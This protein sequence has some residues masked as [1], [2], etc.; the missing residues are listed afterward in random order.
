[1]KKLKA[2]F[3]ILGISVSLLSSCS[4]SDSNKDQSS[5]P[6]PENAVDYTLSVKSEGG[7]SIGDVTVHIFDKETKTDL[8]WAGMTDEDGNFSFKADGA[9]EYVAVVTG[10]AEGYKVEP[11]YSLSK[12]TEIKL[13]TVLL[14]PN[15]ESD[16]YKLGDIV[17]DF[18]ITDVNGN[19]YKMSELLKEKKAV[20]LNFWFIG[21]GP[22]KMEFP[23]MQEAYG[24]FKDEIEILAINAYDGTDKTVKEYAAEM[25]LT[26]PML[27]CESEWITMFRI[28]AFPTTVVIDRYGMVAFSHTGSITDKA[29]FTKI[30][31]HFVSDGYVQNTYRNISDIK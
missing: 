1:M 30:F 11:E 12:N 14:E 22:C 27:S 26:M 6:V 28:S 8:V 5:F 3:L 31:S 16:K 21:C 20:I 4:D 2:L 7:M 25:S 18:S 19:S 23:Y 29:I 13:K 10:V 17:K 15:Y 9:R 24:E